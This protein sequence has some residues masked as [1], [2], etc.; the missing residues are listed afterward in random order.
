LWNVLN[1]SWLEN[2]SKVEGARPVLGQERP[3]GGEV[4][5]LHHLGLLVGRVLGGAMALG[6][7]VEGVGQVALLLG[8]VTGLAQLVPT[9]VPERLDAVPD[10]RVGVVPQPG[11]RLHD[12]G[13]GVVHHPPAAVRHGEMLA[14]AVTPDTVAWF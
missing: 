6:E 9:R 8:H 10:G 11:R 2:P 5:P 13:V 3:G 4:L 14:R 7:P 1:T 12:V